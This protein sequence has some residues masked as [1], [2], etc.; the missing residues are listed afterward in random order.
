MQKTLSLIVFLILIVSA[1]FAQELL[2]E[3]YPEGTEFWL[4]IPYSTIKYKV[5]DTLA[6]YHVSVEIRDS[7]KKLAIL[8]EQ[9]LSVPRSEWLTDTAL[10]IRFSGKL[11]SGKHSASIKLRNLHLGDKY[12][13]KRSFEISGKYADKGLAYLIATKEGISY[14]PGSMAQL[15]PA[16]DSLCLV[17]YF[18]AAVDSMSIQIGAERL[19]LV[20][21]SSPIIVEIMP[22]IDLLNPQA[23]SIT[24][25]ERNVYYKMEPFLY[26]P[27]FS[28]GLKYSL[29]DQM[30]QIRYIASQTEWRVLRK[31]QADQFQ[32]AV[33]QFWTLHDP[34][35]GTL[36]NEAREQFYQRVILA[37]ERYSIHKR[38]Q[39][40]KSDRGRIY[41]KYGDPDEISS[42]VLPIGEYPLIIWTYYSQ[43]L[44][45]I[46][47][48]IGGYGQYQLRNKDEEYEDY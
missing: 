27:W 46:F 25:F 42:E 7:R 28:Y 33:D 6:K 32:I 30:A 37:D 9:Q 21:P 3:S 17:Q 1:G 45:F 5:G 41:I 14:L 22:W 19:S 26:R 18:S 8:H 24:Y 2:F 16:P 48:D 34:S 20:Q 38:L 29:K 39:G 10:V 12:N 13:L 15:S 36:R 44:E 40:W 4:T 23:I 31:V 47:A 35:P 43:N 11:Q